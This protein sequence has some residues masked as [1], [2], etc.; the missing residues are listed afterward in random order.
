MV[1]C[2]TGKSILNLN[3]TIFKIMPEYLLSDQEKLFDEIPSLKISSDCPFKMS[4]V[5]KVCKILNGYAL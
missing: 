5:K 2:V 4:I 3:L 1:E